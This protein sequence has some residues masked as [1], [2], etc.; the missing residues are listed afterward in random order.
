MEQTFQ[1]SFIPKKPIVESDAPKRPSQPIG[2]FT[3]L[4]I[5]LFMSSIIAGTGMYFYK[6]TLE[7][8]IVASE[9]NLAKA[10]D[11]VQKTKKDELKLFDR[12]IN[13][14]SQVLNNHI[15]V[16]PIFEAL[17]KVTMKSVRYTNFSY[18]LGEKKGDRI[19]IKLS[20][21]TQPGRTQ[22]F[23][24]LGLQAELFTK[25]KNFIDPV[26]SNMVK[27][28]KGE[29]TFDI[30]FYVDPSF[31]DYKE[32]YKSGGFEVFKN[33]PTNQKPPLIN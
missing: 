11:R 12:R 22:P 28:A 6:K 26:F 33:F 1:T 27:T 23:S 24:E 21:T 10:E 17:G 29:V 7:Q 30:D 14:A 31:V 3:V 19:K 32:V 20:G 5:F 16:Y 15:A 13:V 18:A 9:D 25:E 2:L 8:K 4:A